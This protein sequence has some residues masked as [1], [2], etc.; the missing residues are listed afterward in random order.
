M[1][2]SIS[3][4]RHILI[5]LIF[6][7]IFS[8]AAAQNTGAP[9]KLVAFINDA[10]L[11]V[12]VRGG[13]KQN[14][15]DVLPLI[16]RTKKYLQRPVSGNLSYAVPYF[17]VGVA[18]RA[19]GA[20]V[21]AS[22]RQ[23]QKARSSF[24]FQGGPR[25]FS[26][27]ATGYTEWKL[28]AEYFVR[29]WIGA[30]VA[31]DHSGITIGST[32]SFP[33]NGQQTSQQ[34][35]RLFTGTSYQNTYSLYVPLR[36]KWGPIRFFGRIGAALGTGDDKYN[37]DFVYY[38]SPE[39]PNEELD[40]EEVPRESFNNKSA[41]ANAQFGQVGVAVPVWRTTIRTSVEAKRMHVPDRTTTWSYD[42]QLE[43]GLPF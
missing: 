18:L 13:V 24:R 19:R 43:V 12:Q 22:Y 6:L 1:N 34:S 8:P 2:S 26:Y 29:D 36:Q 16:D 39:N 5:T 4:L 15:H 3:N 30:G 10:Q 20:E 11:G 23:G 37:T 38:Q 14:Y 21:A 33:F 25:A 41:T 31:Y 17:G 28:R 42:V 7:L 32:G 9:E 27:E 35:I 40:S